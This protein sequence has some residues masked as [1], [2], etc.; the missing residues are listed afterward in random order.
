MNSV[1]VG[2]RFQGDASV[3][4]NDIRYRYYM[5]LP[6]GIALKNVVFHYTD[7]FT[8]VSAPTV[9]IPDVPAGGLLDFTTPETPPTGI[10]VTMCACG[11]ISLLIWNSPTVPEWVMLRLFRIPFR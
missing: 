6:S 2:E 11:G 3:R 4:T 7:D 9:A 1:G 8:D 5:Q 10:R